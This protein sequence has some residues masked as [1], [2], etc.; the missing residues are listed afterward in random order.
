[1]HLL[2]SPLCAPPEALARFGFIPN[3]DRRYV[4]AMAYVM[5]ESIGRVVEALK[6]S[7]RMCVESSRPCLPRP[8]IRIPSTYGYCG[9]GL[10]AVPRSLHST[11]STA[12]LPST[13]YTHTLNLWLCVCG[14]CARL[15]VPRLGTRCSALLT[16]IAAQL[17]TL[18]T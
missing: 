2:H 13:S 11:L 17:Y 18:L 4:A 10:V 14:C 6:A 7:H 3:E 1:M 8:P 16:A 12:V 15:I 5:D 9:C